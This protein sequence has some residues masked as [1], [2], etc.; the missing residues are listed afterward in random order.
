MKFLIVEDLT[1]M[2]RVIANTLKTIGYEEVIE[3][4]SG[5]EAYNIML[6]KPVDFMITDWLMPNMDGLELIKKMKANDNLKDI[7]VIMLTTK[8]NKDDVLTA[9]TA[10]INGYIVKPFNAQVL[11]DKIDS[12]VNPFKTYE[13]E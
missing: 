6:S 12:I 1:I 10:Q 11:K 7:P 2:R 9:F 3:A 5:E 8:G 13:F 4:S